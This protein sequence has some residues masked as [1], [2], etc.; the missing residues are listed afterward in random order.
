M[1]IVLIGMRGSG[2]STVAKILAERL[3]RPYVEMDDEV[4]KR[5]CMTIVDIFAKHGP[6]YFRD[7]ESEVVD[8]LMTHTDAIISTGGGVVLRDRNVQMLKKNSVCIW[9]K[10]PAES[11]LQHTE[12]DPKTAH[13]RPKLTDKEYPLEEVHELMRIREPLY[14]KAADEIIDTESLLLEDVA[15]KI[16]QIMQK[17]RI[18]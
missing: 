10:A 7:R 17:R 14:E 1:N 9:L 3:K 16:V 2:K 4:V 13:H 6:E 12:N 11:L 8:E 5:S 15:Q 18:T